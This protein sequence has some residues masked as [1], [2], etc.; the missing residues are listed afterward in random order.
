M[1]TYR[2]EQWNRHEERWHVWKEYESGWPLTEI[3]KTAIRVHH[4]GRT[5]MR[6]V[7]ILAN[8]EVVLPS[9]YVDSLTRFT[10]RVHMGLE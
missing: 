1:I 5:R 4:H 10:Q 3:R 6:I 8:R 9:I 2:I 7:K